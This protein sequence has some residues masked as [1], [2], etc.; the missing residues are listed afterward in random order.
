MTAD[1]A[2][3]YDPS[4]GA[5]LCVRPRIRRSSDHV[6]FSGLCDRRQTLAAEQWAGVIR[7]RRHVRTREGSIRS[8][9]GRVPGGARVGVAAAALISMPANMRTALEFDLCRPDSGVVLHDLTAN[10]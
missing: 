7:R 1:Q 4:Y 6:P 5:R 3:L 9:F 10:G 8:E 2:S